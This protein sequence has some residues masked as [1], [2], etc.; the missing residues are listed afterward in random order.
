MSS[1]NEYKPL[2]RLIKKTTIENLW[3]YLLTELKKGDQHPY[4][5]I[6]KIHE[7]YSFNPGKVLPYVVLKKLER[8]NFVESYT[9]EN[10]HYYKITEKGIKLL[11]EGANYLKNILKILTEN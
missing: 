8:E 1:K 5:L 2:R 10:R 4:A 9:K 11:G 7:K 3:L 6:K